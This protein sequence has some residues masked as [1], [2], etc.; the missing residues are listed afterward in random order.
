MNFSVKSRRSPAE[1]FF[2]K[3]MLAKS[4]SKKIDKKNFYLF[5]LRER[6]TDGPDRHANRQKSSA[7]YRFRRR[8]VARRSQNYL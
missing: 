3:K 1:K 7:D 8:L 5:I 4:G 2:S 6:S